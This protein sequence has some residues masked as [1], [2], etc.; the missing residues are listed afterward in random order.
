M[1][2]ARGWP[3]DKD[4]IERMVERAGLP[5]V[6]RWSRRHYQ[7]G[8]RRAWLG[9]LLHGASVQAGERNIQHRLLTGTPEHFGPKPK[10]PPINGF[11][12]RISNRNAVDIDVFPLVVIVCNSF[13]CD[14][15]LV[16]T[17]SRGERFESAR[18]SFACELICHRP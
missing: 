16:L 18:R 13:P 4:T 7:H 6:P 1:V 8:N 3:Q 14:C 15:E 5:P 12:K 17:A 2:G 10:R 11:Y 9:D